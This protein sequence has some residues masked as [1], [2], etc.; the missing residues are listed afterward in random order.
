MPLHLSPAGG[1][2]RLDSWMLATIA[3]LATYRFCRRFLTRE[4]DP[5]G[6]Q[7]DQMTQADC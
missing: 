7:Y 1:Y 2:R 3:Q 6:R 5:T 4:L